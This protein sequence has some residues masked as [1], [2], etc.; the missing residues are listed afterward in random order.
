M[1]YSLS[2]SIW[3]LSVHH[4]SNEYW[5]WYFRFRLDKTSLFNRNSNIVFKLIWHLRQSARWSNWR[6]RGDFWNFRQSARFSNWRCR[7]ISGILVRRIKVIVNIVISN[8][9]C[10]ILWDVLCWILF[11]SLHHR[12]VL[13]CRNIHW[14]SILE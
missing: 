11:C 12:N 14:R 2:T 8:T 9:N 6:C 4:V 1:P 13:R 10:D 7:G 5:K 3:F